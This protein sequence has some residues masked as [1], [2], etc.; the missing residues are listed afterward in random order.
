MGVQAGAQFGEGGSTADGG[1][2]AEVVYGLVGVF[3]RAVEVADGDMGFG[4]AGETQGR[5]ARVLRT[6]VRRARRG[7]QLSEQEAAALEAVAAD[8]PYTG[9]TWR[10]FARAAESAGL[11]GAFARLN[12]WCRAH[13]WNLKCEDAEHA[14]HKAAGLAAHRPGGGAWQNEAWRTSFTRYWA[15][16]YTPTSRDRPPLLALLR[17]QQLYD[18]DFPFRWR[19]RVLAAVAGVRADTPGL[20]TKAAAAAAQRGLHLQALT[21]AQRGFWLTDTEAHALEV[22]EQTARIL[23][24]SACWDG[25]WNVWPATVDEAVGLL[26]DDQ[27][28]AETV[29]TCLRRNAAVAR[30]DPRHTID[31]LDSRR[32]A[33]HLAARWNLPADADERA[34]DAV[35]RDRGM[36]SFAAAVETAR[37]FYL[38]E[39]T[40]LTVTETC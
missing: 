37:A 16:A 22:T 11:H 15:S 40:K 30:A 20:E 17:H 1:D 32:I 4:S 23:V 7:R 13:P 8:L 12:V 19:A 18:P 27:A 35:T 2:A 3:Q 5:G 14:L 9:R 36:R 33:Q 28:T 34:R 29:T 6:A 24:R 10:A 25:A 31:R 26:D 38:T 21:D 39:R